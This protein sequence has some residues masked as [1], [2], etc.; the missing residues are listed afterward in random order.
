ML[1]YAYAHAPIVA[2][3]LRLHPLT[4]AKHTPVHTMKL[5]LEILLEQCTE[6]WAKCTVPCIA[7]CP[8]KRRPFKHP[9]LV[10]LPLPS[11][12]LDCFLHYVSLIDA[13]GSAP[14]HKVKRGSN[15]YAA[16]IAAT[17]LSLGYIKYVLSPRQSNDV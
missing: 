4:D 15:G 6:C 5:K 1:L 14:G 7:S 16:F 8:G 10:T 9:G 2:T 11:V 3:H 17:G 12:P 13:R